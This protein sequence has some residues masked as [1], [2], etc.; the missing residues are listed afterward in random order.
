LLKR[1]KTLKANLSVD[2]YQEVKST[3]IDNKRWASFN[4]LKVMP[5]LIIQISF[6]LQI[7]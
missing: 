5:Q 2:L 7:M 3:K 1:K 6:F 4:D